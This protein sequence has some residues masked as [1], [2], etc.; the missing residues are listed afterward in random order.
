MMFDNIYEQSDLTTS[1]AVSV[2]GYKDSSASLE[3]QLQ[4]L[5]I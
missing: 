1:L 4:D 5:D 3:S 2:R